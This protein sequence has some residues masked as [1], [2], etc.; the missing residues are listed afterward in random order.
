MN[1]GVTHKLFT[2]I[3]HHPNLSQRELA[4]EMGISLGKTNYCIKG[5]MERGWLKARN[6]KNSNNKIAYAYILTPTG[7][8]EKAKIT[9]R[10]LKHKIQEYETLKS[11]IEK[12]RKEV[13]GSS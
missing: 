9:A 2:L 4:R 10:Y 5:L 6:F 11:E 8:S 3:E 1:D 13:S 12:L 7:I